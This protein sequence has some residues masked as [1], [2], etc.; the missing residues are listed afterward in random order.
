M[1]AAQRARAAVGFYV[2][3][4]AETFNACR[5][6]EYIHKLALEAKT[7]KVEKQKIWDDLCDLRDQKA[8][9]DD[10]VKQ[11]KYNEGDFVRVLARMNDDLVKGED[12]LQDVW[13]SFL[14][15]H[16]GPM[17]LVEQYEAVAD[18]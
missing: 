12:N 7:V 1:Q 6:E 9:V 3:M 8:L 10:T 5:F 16:R 17:Q 4:F 2:M 14:T 13:D 15:L 11:L 18:E